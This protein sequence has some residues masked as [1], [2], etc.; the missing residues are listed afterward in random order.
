[1]KITKQQLKRIIRES[2]L[3]EEVEKDVLD[4]LV[5]GDSTT[6][7]DILYT[8]FGDDADVFFDEMRSMLSKQ[9]VTKDQADA[10]VRELDNLLT[11]APVSPTSSSKSGGGGIM[12]IVKKYGGKRVASTGPKPPP[13]VKVPQ[14][15]EFPDQGTAAKVVW[16]ISDAT[17]REAVNDGNVITVYP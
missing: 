13:G 7:A 10:T 4:A 6:A 9:G 15:Y 2:L 14:Q 3:V 12:D 11:G 1:M 5:A 16:L 8:E 17:G